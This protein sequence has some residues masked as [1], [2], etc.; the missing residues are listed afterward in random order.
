[1]K[2]S[3]YFSSISGQVESS[4]S[5]SMAQRAV[6][7]ASLCKAPVEI[8]SVSPCSDIDAAVQAARSVGAEV[9]EEGSVLKVAPGQQAFHHIIN[10]NEAGL[11][12]RMFA[13]IAAL[14]SEQFSFSGRGSLMKRPV[15]MIEEALT[16]LGVYCSTN[17]GYLP[18]T[19]QGPITKTSLKIDGAI[20]SQLL[21][22]L[23]IALPQCETDTTIEVINLK[24]RPYI[25]MTLDI[26][27]DFGGTIEH[28]DYAL[29]TIPGRQS[30]T[31]EKYVV[32]GDWSSASTLLA[33]AA[34]T[35]NITVTN[36]RKNSPQAD[37][38]M[39]DALKDVGADVVVR[40]TG[41]SVR[42]KDLIPF[43]FDATDSPDLFPALTALA[44]GIQGTSV[45]SGTHRLIHKESNRKETLISE[46]SKIGVDVKEEGDS[47]AVTGGSIPGGSADSCND[48]RIAMAL[49]CAALVSKNGVAI[50]HAEAVE[51]SYPHFFTDLAA[52]G[53]DVR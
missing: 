7:L 9:V 42:K 26:I 25:D 34:L 18:M 19:I 3:V 4:A 53:G 23:L 41:V 28:D 43:S 10:C 50:E 27:S 36:L 29:F 49:A 47:L 8:H 33:A 24:S 17:G 21:T 15:T 11:S 13:P 48:H 39:I 5:K 12:V 46:F 51:K 44:A 22:G 38:S 20:S 16:Q 37:M 1:M 14:Y 6:A 2:K 32:E 30:Y 35:G 52:L 45:I 31:K 40:D